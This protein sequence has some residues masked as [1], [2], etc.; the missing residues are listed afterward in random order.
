MFDILI[1][2]DE[3]LARETVKLLLAPFLIKLLLVQSKLQKPPKNKPLLGEKP[4]CSSPQY[5][6]E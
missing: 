3:T 6:S 4:N 5:P 1:A 2:D